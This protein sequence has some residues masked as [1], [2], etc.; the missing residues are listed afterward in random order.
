MHLRTLPISLPPMSREAIGSYRLGTSGGV[1]WRTAVTLRI[2]RISGVVE[3]H[4]GG[5]RFWFTL[6][7]RS[8]PE[9]A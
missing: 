2:V 4:G 5:S 6:P 8:G 1:P 3:R 9:G 7:A